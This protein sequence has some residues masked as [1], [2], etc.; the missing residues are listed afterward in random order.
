M[1][2]ATVSPNTK[3]FLHQRQG[4]TDSVFDFYKQEI[5]TYPLSN[6]FHLICLPVSN[7]SSS[8][9]VVRCED[10]NINICHGFLKVMSSVLRQG[11]VGPSLAPRSVELPSVLLQVTC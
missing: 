7:L 6:K 11:H 8:Q 3:D 1:V 4:A 9:S 2:A 5:F 10:G